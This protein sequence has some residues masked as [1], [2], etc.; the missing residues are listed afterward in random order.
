MRAAG[1]YGYVIFSPSRGILLMNEIQIQTVL[2]GCMTSKDITNG[3]VSAA[4]AARAKS[5][6]K[7][8]RHFYVSLCV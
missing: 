3:N 5:L 2:Y 6:K 4:R 8:V 1:E 7:Y